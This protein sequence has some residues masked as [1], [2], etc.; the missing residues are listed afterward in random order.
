MINTLTGD[1]VFDDGLHLGPSASVEAL[2]AIPGARRG[3]AILGRTQLSVGSHRVAAI[4]WGV[5]AV[6]VERQLAQVLLQ[7]LNAPSVQRDV[8][9][10]ANETIRKNAHDEILRNLF[11]EQSSL[12]KSAGPQTPLVFQL[13]WGRISS[14]LDPRGVQALILI[15]YLPTQ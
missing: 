10:M 2:E 6:F 11:G 14:I 3:P 4:E 5:G 13:S 15:E 1:V 9:G 7:Y 8:L 12:N